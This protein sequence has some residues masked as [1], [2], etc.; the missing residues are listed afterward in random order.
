MRKAVREAKVATSWLHPHAAYEEALAGFIDAILDPASGAAFLADFMVAQARL[1]RYGFLNGLAQTL[2][3][4]AAPGVPDCYQGSE[5]WDLR[6]VDP[7]NRGPV[8]FDVRRAKLD[9]VQAIDLDAPGAAAQVRALCDMPGDGRAKLHVIA[10]ALAL[11]A[12]APDLFAFGDYRPLR[13]T[14]ARAAHVVAFA[15]TLG[16]DALVAVVPRLVVRLLGGRADALP[17]GAATWR[18]TTVTL[19]AMPGCWRNALTGAA[20]ATGPAQDPSHAMLAAILADFPVA[21]LEAA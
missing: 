7:D 13:A 9:A 16:D 18:D 5:L 21:L 3:K 8:D 14:G 1:A 19:P 2:L 11:R 20:L 12:R 10:R 17:L 4:L 6:L 15:R